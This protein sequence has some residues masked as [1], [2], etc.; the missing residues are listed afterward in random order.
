MPKPHN[1]DAFRAT[2]DQIDGLI[3]CDLGLVRRTIQSTP[4]VDGPV[5]IHGVGEN[6]ARIILKEFFIVE[7]SV[8][9]ATISRF[10][11]RTS[12]RHCHRLGHVAW[13]ELV[14]GSPRND[15]P[16]IQY[17]ALCGC[18]F[19]DF[20]LDF[21]SL[22]ISD[23]E[24]LVQNRIAGRPAAPN[25]F[26]VVNYDRADWQYE[27]D[28]SKATIRSLQEE[29]DKLQELSQ[30]AKQFEA[31]SLAR[32]KA[33]RL[34]NQRYDGVKKKNEEIKKELNELKH[35]NAVLRG[36]VSDQETPHG[37]A[38]AEHKNAQAGYDNK[39]LQAE[40]E[41]EDVVIL[42]PKNTPCAAV[43][44]SVAVQVTQVSS[45]SG[46]NAERLLDLERRLAEAE[47]KAAAAEGRAAAAENI[48]A[49]AEARTAAVEKKA[50]AAEARTAAAEKKATA[51]VR[52]AA[53]AK[54]AHT[55]V[56]NAL[57]KLL[58]SAAKHST[59]VAARHSVA[60]AEAAA[61][62]AAKKYSAVE[63]ELKAKNAKIAEYENRMD[64]IKAEP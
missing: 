60:R 47:K 26:P 22:V 39:N 59:V 8:F 37:D 64:G 1:F 54:D 4:R 25:A 24:R 63:E 14:E 27:L 44:S 19:G 11:N 53:K 45:V 42:E 52:H 41:D 34:A 18:E 23:P 6:Y 17:R 20:A 10:A 13:W 28:L 58:E 29:N 36:G 43:K 12:V 21:P 7:V 9:T 15:A 61:R 62:A 50:T 38:Q 33:L 48:V 5:V 55:T 3:E 56:Q 51:A 35:A 32:L 49:A 30:R 2:L 40:N 46:D 57:E 16:G 31:S